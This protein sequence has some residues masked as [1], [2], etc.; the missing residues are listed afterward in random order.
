MWQTKRPAK[1]FEPLDYLMLFF[2][3]P[4]AEVTTGAMLVIDVLVLL[5]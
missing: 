5:I 4:K 1:V 3:T 2:H